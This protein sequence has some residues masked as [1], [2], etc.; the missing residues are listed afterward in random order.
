V[1]SPRIRHCSRQSA[2]IA[3]PRP[4]Y[5]FSGLFPNRATPEL[6]RLQVEL[7]STHLFREAATLIEMFLPWSAQLNTTVRNCLGR[8]ADELGFDEDGQ[9]DAGTD[10]ASSPITVFLDGAHIRCRPEYQKRHLD[11]VMGKIESHDKCRRFDLVQQAVLSPANQLR[12]DLRALGWD[13]RQTVTVISDGEPALRC[14]GSGRNRRTCSKSSGNDNTYSEGSFSR[15]SH[16]W[17]TQHRSKWTRT[18]NSPRCPRT[19][20][21]A[22]PCVDGSC[23]ARF[24]LTS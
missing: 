8:I 15:S 9:G 21:V 20:A 19:S 18:G 23:L 10:A 13:Q 7:E 17:T 12:Q 6:R 1:K 2:G 22:L 5:L 3:N 4:Q 16:S 14:S 24:F 11:V